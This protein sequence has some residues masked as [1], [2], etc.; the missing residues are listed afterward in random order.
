MKNYL[1]RA[2]TIA[3]K[4]KTFL[5]NFSY[6]A[7]LQVFNL[8]LP[9]ITYPYLI[10][11]LGKENYGL[12]VYAGA[13]IQY[14]IMIINFGFNISAT[15]AISIH[16]DDSKKISEIVSSIL[17][18]KTILF[19]TSFSI[20]GLL[21]AFIPLFRE[22]SILFIFS[23]A[24][25]IQQTI[26]PTYYF[27]GIEK[28]GFVTKI[29]ML[30]RTIFTVLI[31]L[32]IKKETDYL[33]VPLINGVGA[34]I[35]GLV[36]I[37]LTFSKTNIK[38]FIPTFN[39]LTANFKAGINFFLSNLSI[40]GY[41][42]ANK[43]F[44]GSFSSMADVAYYDLGEKVL[45]LL[46]SFVSTIEQ[47]IFPRVSLN[48][49]K[50][51]LKRIRTLTLISTT[52]VIVLIFVFTKTIV[53]ILGG[54]LMYEAILPLR[55]LS[56]SIIPIIISMFWGHLMLIIWGFNKDFLKLR[57]ISLISYFGLISIHIIITPLNSIT[58]SILTLT[59]EILIACYSYYF[60]KK[61]K[62]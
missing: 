4:N 49:D 54:N 32:V 52:G 23:M 27:Q 40:L 11:V 61:N 57:L 21:I 22:N 13:V 46:K 50:L 60:I 58:L 12:T 18:L 38:F 16:R 28:M 15:Q 35:A 3:T 48:K 8:I 25:C 39:I 42:S 6:L 44:L 53:S 20:L 2:K 36:A 19:L 1:S 34:F 30:A 9:L 37:Y 33:Y 62:L 10:R 45:G 24:L 41:S 7:I 43:L 59:N 47:V 51:L 26:F 5:E 55:I 17:I 56:L 14:F 29:T 31:F